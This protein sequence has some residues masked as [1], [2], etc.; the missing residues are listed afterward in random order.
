MIIALLKVRRG[1][2]KRDNC[3]ILYFIFI[4]NGK[5]TF[6]SS[7]RYF[8]EPLIRFNFLAISAYTIARVHAHPCWCAAGIAGVFSWT[9]GSLRNGWKGYCRRGAKV[10]DPGY[11]SRVRLRFTFSTN[12]LAA[13]YRRIYTL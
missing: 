8:Q 2:R 1:R 4:C 11:F 5:R 6:C 10:G 12:T 9:N 3:Y 13:S 7:R